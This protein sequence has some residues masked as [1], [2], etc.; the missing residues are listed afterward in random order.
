MDEVLWVPTLKRNY[1]RIVAD[2]IT[3]RSFQR[4]EEPDHTTPSEPS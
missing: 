1:V 2:E 3:G 4:T